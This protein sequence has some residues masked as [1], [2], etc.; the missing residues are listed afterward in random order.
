MVFVYLSVCMFEC[1]CVCGHGLFCKNLSSNMNL[2]LK[3]P[4][5]A[6]KRPEVI[7]D[8]IRENWI[9]EIASLPGRLEAALSGWADEQ[10]DTPYR[11]GGWSALTEENPTIKPYNQDEWAEL[12]DVL[13]LPVSHSFDIIRG[14]H[15][16]WVFLLKRLNASD[17]QRT[18]VHPEHG[19]VFTVEDLIGQYAWHGNHHLA[20]I[21]ELTKREFDR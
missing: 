1:L 3:Y 17:L 14:L 18:L 20:H 16:R 21:T 4:I 2:H 13:L 9:D 10:L 11:P 7:T 19:K 15:A 12:P 5:G 6:Y 8:G